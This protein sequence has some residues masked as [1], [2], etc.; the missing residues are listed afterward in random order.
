MKTRFDLEQE[1]MECWNITSD[2]EDV[3]RYVVEGEPN[4]DTTQ[5][6][7]VANILL[8]LAQLYDLKFGKTFNTFTECLERKEFKVEEF[9]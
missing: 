9:E 6:D 3:Y 7:K 1:I 8:G 5:R 2:L 4:M